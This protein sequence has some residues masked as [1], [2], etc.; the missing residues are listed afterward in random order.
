M[1]LASLNTLAKSKDELCDKINH[2]LAPQNIVNKN[3]EIS[4]KTHW[5]QVYINSVKISKSVLE[6]NLLSSSHRTQ[7]VKNQAKTLILRLAE[8]QQKIQSRPQKLFKVRTLTSEEWDTVT[9]NGDIQKDY[10]EAEIF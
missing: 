4:D 5:L 2:C 10:I 9:W 7:H 8:L 3:S 6:E 1:V